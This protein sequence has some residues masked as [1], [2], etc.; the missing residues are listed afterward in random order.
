LED[1]Q[2][3]VQCL[4]EA[5]NMATGRQL[6]NLFATILRECAPSDPVHLWNTYWPHICDDLRYQLQHHNIRINPTDD[7]VQD[8]GLFLIDEILKASNKSLQA[9][10]PHMPHSTQNWEVDLGNRLILEQ[11]RYD[12][13][14]QAVLAAGNEQNFNADQQTAYQEILHAVREKTGQTFFL[15]GPGGTGKT[16]VYN[17][18]CHRLRSEGKIVLCV[19]SSGI[20][21]LLLPG[22]RTVHSSF[23][24]HPTNINESTTCSI[25]RG[26]LKAGLLNQTDLIIWD[27]AIMQHRHIPEAVERSLR[28][29]RQID[30]PFGGIT[31]VF[32]GDFHQILPVI[33]RG[34]RPQLVGASLQRSVL[35]HNIKVLHLKINMR[36]NTNNAQERDFAQWQLEVGKG[37]HTDDNCNITLPDHFKCP[38]NTVSSLI[39]TIY[40]GISNPHQHP[41]EYFS[42]RVILACRNDDVDDLNHTVLQKFPGQER[43][44]HSADSIANDGM[45]ELLYPTEYLNSLNCSGLPLAHL[46]LKVG[47]PVMVL[48]NLNLE[49]GVCN[50]TEEL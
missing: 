27:E 30:R 39:N 4:E 20:A 19:A 37:G 40:P 36:L 13:E 35:W 5:K 14:E 46:A 45:D 26:T 23:N 48:R 11:R 22:G 50:G 49:G 25:S 33:E 7:D 42:Q 18:L 16:Y 21:A 8:Y 29:I 28:D 15:H 2:E 43:V 12:V 9:N 41:D 34:S 1:D 44:F 31:V 6:R 38:E 10:W 24:I 47:C 32:G 3:W 17:T